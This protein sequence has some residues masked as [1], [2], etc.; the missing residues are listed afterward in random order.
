MSAPIISV[1]LGPL[2]EKWLQYC[3]SKGV[4]SSAAL[5]QVVHHLITKDGCNEAVAADYVDEGKTKRIE[6]RLKP[7][8]YAELKRRAATEGLSPNR[9]LIALVDARISKTVPKF[10]QYELDGLTASTSQLLRLGTNLNQIARAI[11]RNPLETDLA[12]VELIQEIR[13]EINL[14]T[15]HVAALIANNLKRWQ[16]GKHE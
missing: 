13:Q 6:I 16:G 5:R 9:F 3:L 12:R 7:A 2:R 11:N 1:Y 15:Q 10:G 4:T 14:H 8:Q